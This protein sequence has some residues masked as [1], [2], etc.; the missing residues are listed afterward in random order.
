MHP[1]CR[2]SR[3]RLRLRRH[4]GCPPAA[5][6]SRRA[7][8]AARRLQAPLQRWRQRLAPSHTSSFIGTADCISLI[9][10]DKEVSERGLSA[11]AVHPTWFTACTSESTQTSQLYC[12]FKQ[13]LHLMMLSISHSLPANTPRLIN[14]KN[15]PDLEIMS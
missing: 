12:T 11:S 6:A 2:Q 8:P 10:K 3:S 1:C 14:E 5:A 9:D 4:G 13:G 7:G 15:V